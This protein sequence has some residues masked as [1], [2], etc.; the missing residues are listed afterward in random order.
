[1][2]GCVIDVEPSGSATPASF[3]S[4]ISSIVYGQICYLS[5]CAFR[6]IN[7]M[8]LTTETALKTFLLPHMYV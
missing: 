8:P 5:P 2:A 4:K 7:R 3:S 1:M 6:L